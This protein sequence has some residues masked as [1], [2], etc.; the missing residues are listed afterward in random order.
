MQCYLDFNPNPEGI[1]EL[2][3]KLLMENVKRYYK[4]PIVLNAN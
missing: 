1:T 2:D 4:M 3:Q